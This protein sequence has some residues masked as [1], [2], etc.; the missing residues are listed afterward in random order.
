MYA[1]ELNL[2]ATRLALLGRSGGGQL[3]LL[4]A[5]T[6]GEPS[7]RG[8]ISVAA[9]TDL[10]YNYE[11]PARRGLLDTRAALESYLGGTPSTADGAYF[12]A[13]PIN[14]VSAGSPPTLLIHGLQDGHVSPEESARLEARLQ[15][16]S[17]K[18]MFVR[19]PWATHGCDWSFNGPCG[20]ITTYAVEQF[21]N[22][23]MATPK[24]APKEPSRLARRQR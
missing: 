15:K 19:L 11:N 2:D 9:P 17:V 5:Y 16:A 22:R 13:S 3:A 10:R 6:A 8:V 14:F 21:L 24:P 4:A 12:A 1:K 20:Q 23:V 18:N 7:I